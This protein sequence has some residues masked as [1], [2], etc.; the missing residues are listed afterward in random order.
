MNEA[1][2]TQGS[3]RMRLTL[4]TAGV[5]FVVGA[6]LLALTYVLVL[7]TVPPETPVQALR[8]QEVLICEQQQRIAAATPHPIQPSVGVEGD[9]T[10]CRDAAP[11]QAAGIGSTANRSSTLHDLLWFSVLGLILMTGVAAAQQHG[12]FQE[13]RCGLSVTSRTWRRGRRGPR[14]ENDLSF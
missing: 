5:F 7:T 9:L 10:Y 8:Q 13:G 3:L 12:P 2:Q 11:A 1:V 14:S 4:L 6:G